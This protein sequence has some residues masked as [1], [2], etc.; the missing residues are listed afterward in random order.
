MSAHQ[1]RFA[2]DLGVADRHLD[3]RFLVHAGDPLG[4][5]VPAVVSNRFDNS[6][7]IA[8]RHCKR[9][10][11]AEGFEYIDHEIGSGTA[12]TARLRACSRS[13]SSLRWR[14]WL[15]EDGFRDKGSRTCGRPLQEISPI[16]G[17]LLTFLHSLPHESL[18]HWER[19]ARSAG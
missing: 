13:S 1:R 16:D 18:S 5:L 3:G 19:V 12:F 7:E 2:L 6:G 11:D 9:I 15:R 17:T 4:I 8:G 14:L 10:F